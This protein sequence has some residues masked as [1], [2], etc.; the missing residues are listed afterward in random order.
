MLYKNL[1]FI[2]SVTNINKH[3]AP[4]LLKF[5]I[6]FNEILFVSDEKIWNANKKF[7]PQNFLNKFGD[8]LLL[9]KPI[10]EISFVEKII[11]K[12]KNF[13]LILAF[14]SGTISDL[15]KFASF[16]NNIDYAIVISALS[17]NG[18]MAKNA[19]ITV[20]DHK[21]TLSAHL[22]KIILADMRILKN[23][24]IELTK[25]GIADVLCFLACKFDIEMN[26]MIFGVKI[27]KEAVNIQE[28]IIK[29]FVKNYESFDLKDNKFLKT[30]LM[31][32]INS[33]YAMTLNNS[34]KPASQTEHL[35]AHYLT[36][37]K[38]EIVNE[39]LH[40]KLIAITVISALKAHMA[41][42]KLMEINQLNNNI[43][44]LFNEEFPSKKLQDKLS[45]KIIYE[46]HEEFVNKINFIK[47]NQE[48]LKNFEKNNKKIFKKLYKIHQDSLVIYAIFNHFKITYDNNE[49]NIGESEIQEAIYFAKYIRN[50]ITALDLLYFC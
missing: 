5:N 42:I 31:I 17:M 20:N 24:P 40:G 14:G 12:S 27:K 10:A 44:K 15:C 4:I 38:P 6:Q 47:N 28:N 19:S 9:E 36:M 25:A 45:H 26:D 1:V 32:I 49:V 34:S 8:V 16:K 11:E 7:F 18:Y 30:L 37:K 3:L 50:R 2:K 23:S 41:I 13:K 46:C 29:N 39:I 43:L 35:I 21:K 22:P 33:G 48:L